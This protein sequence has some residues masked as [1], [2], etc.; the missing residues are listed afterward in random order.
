LASVDGGA[1]FIGLP[2]FAVDRDI[3]VDVNGTTG[4]PTWINRGELDKPVLT[5]QLDTAQEGSYQVSI[6]CDTD[7][8]V[9]CLVV[10]L[11]T[12]I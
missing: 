3:H 5:G 12:T 2:G 8:L 4:I 10:A 1:V 7:E 9:E 6:G 11:A